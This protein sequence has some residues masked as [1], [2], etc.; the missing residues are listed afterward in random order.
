MKKR[1]L[2]NTAKIG[3]TV[4]LLSLIVSGL[5]VTNKLYSEQIMEDDTYVP[6]INQTKDDD[7]KYV[8]ETIEEV[9][10]PTKPFLASNVEIAKNYYNTKDDE[11]KQIGSLIYY[12]DT[13]MQNTGILYKS[14]ESFDVVSTLDGTVTSITKDEILGNVVEISHSN[15]L[16]TIY[17]CLN[18][19]NVKA[20][21]KV[22]Q[23][24]VIGTS[25][26]VNIDDGYENA[27]LFEVNYKG[28]TINPEEYYTM[29]E[30]MLKG[31][32]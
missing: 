32:D 7:S 22:K 6:Q 5:A 13:Y 27:L 8:K 4:L 14:N 15:N 28:S 31:N 21:D 24:D 20:G 10:L 26:K 2:R 3:I 16:I 9:K 23:N 1:K 17:H 11:N 18:E 12:K 29:K 25:G 30:D 19:V